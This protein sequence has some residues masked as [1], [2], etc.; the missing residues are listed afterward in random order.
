MIYVAEKVLMLPIAKMF[1]D[2]INVAKE[3]LTK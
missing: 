1:V 3:V 2:F